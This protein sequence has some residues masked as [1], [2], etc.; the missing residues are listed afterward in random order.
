MLLSKRRLGRRVEI[1]QARSV[2]FTFS[3]AF[4]ASVRPTI[5]SSICKGVWSPLQ[6][7]Y[8]GTSR[9]QWQGGDLGHFPE[10]KTSKE[11]PR[12]LVDL[13]RTHRKEG[14]QRSFLLKI[15]DLPDQV[16]NSLLK[17]TTL[18]HYNSPP[19]PLRGQHHRCPY[20]KQEAE[21]NTGAIREPLGT[22]PAHQILKLIFTSSVLPSTYG[23]RLQNTGHPVR[24][25]IHK[26]QID[27]LVVR[28]VTTCEYPLLYVL[29]LCFCRA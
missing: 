21:S 10:A 26:L 1:S 25:G 20:D 27:G 2:S 4:A 11:L 9:S 23:H 14:G 8:L 6:W 17:P 3:D 29:S 12:S 24:S 18:Q 7:S 5:T 16:S 22:T 19:S 13:D 15:E 28:W